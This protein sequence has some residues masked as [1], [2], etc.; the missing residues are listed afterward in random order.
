[1]C[2]AFLRKGISQSRPD[3]RE[4]N[5]ILQSIWWTVDPTQH[6]YYTMASRMNE[7][8]SKTEREFCIF[9]TECQSPLLVTL[10]RR[11]P[12][13]HDEDGPRHSCERRG[14]G[15]VPSF[16]DPSSW[17]MML[18]FKTPLGRTPST[19]QLSLP[20]INWSSPHY[21]VLLDSPRRHHFF[22]CLYPCGCACR[23]EVRYLPLESEQ[24]RVVVLRL[25]LFWCYYLPVP[26]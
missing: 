14:R 16:S 20:P 4:R 22:E 8:A 10:R 6:C 3:Q 12:H 2:S 11:H 18:G 9:P 13:R 15:S 17:D 23:H 1:M 21:E 25:H 5:V 7:R 26:D 24:R 19:Q